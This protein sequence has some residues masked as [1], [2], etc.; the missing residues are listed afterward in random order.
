MYKND[1]SMNSPTVLKK[2]C[3]SDGVFDMGFYI[4]CRGLTNF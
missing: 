2:K 4:F 3:I 1:I